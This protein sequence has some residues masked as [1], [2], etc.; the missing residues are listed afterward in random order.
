MGVKWEE[1]EF[2]GSEMGYAF[3]GNQPL[4]FIK[5]GF[6]PAP[7]NIPFCGRFILMGKFLPHH[8]KIG[9]LIKNDQPV[10]NKNFL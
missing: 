6:Y 5:C 8:G 3:F 9:K 1:R 7:I 4:S 10:C 2:S